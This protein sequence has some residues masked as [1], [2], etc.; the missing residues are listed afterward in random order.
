V[1]IPILAAVVL[2]F[3]PFGYAVAAGETIK[4]GHV[5]RDCADCPEMVV[6]PP[7]SFD[8]GSP[9]DAAEQGEGEGPLHRVVIR[10]PFALAKTEVTRGQFAAFVA[11]TGYPSGNLCSTFE[12]AKFDHRTGRNWRNPGFPQEDNHPVACINWHDAKAFIQWLATQTGK[13][14][15]LPS[16]A[17]WEYAAR[18]G[19]RTVRYW[20]DNP[21]KA[22]DYAN[23]MD[24][25]SKT[26]VP[27]VYWE[28]HNCADG[29]RFTAPV[30]SFKPNAFGLFDMIGNVWEWTEDCWNPSYANAPA[31]GSAWT[32]GM[33]Q[34]RVLR[35]GSWSKKPG[36]AR[37]AFRVKY[38]PGTRYYNYGIRPALT[39]TTD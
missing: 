13:P 26:E 21:D 12:S 6:I 2:S 17:E 19:T 8:M 16:E 15:R 31:D 3:L 10:K 38:T 1:G 37:S 25:T 14:Y 29:H 22:C 36:F 32:T 24:Q 5:F 35:G 30:G 33:C 7:G 20:G 4:P 28:S 9:A 11:A 18:A 23:V 39:L 27:G 34:W